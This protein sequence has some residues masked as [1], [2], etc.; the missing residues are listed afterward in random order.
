MHCEQCGGRIVPDDKFCENCG[1]QLLEKQ[2]E[3]VIAVEKKGEVVEPSQ[4]EL[5]S[6]FIGP[7]KQTFY[8]GKWNRK[9]QTTFNW[10]AA[11]ATFFWLGYRKMY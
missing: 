4:E 1:H 9:E 8:F 3:K 10:A 11:F 7:K 6:A 2:N 5:L